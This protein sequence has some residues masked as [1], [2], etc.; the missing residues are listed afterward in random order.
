MADG[1]RLTGAAGASLPD[2]TQRA[3][4][5][6]QGLTA[7]RAAAHQ[8][9]PQAT[10]QAAKQFEA[11]FTQMM[12]KSMREAT[13]SGGLLGSDQEKMFNGMLDD[14]LAQQ[15]ASN[16]GIGLADLM[17]KQLARTGTTLPPA[18][19]GRQQ[20]LQGRA[21]N[22]A[23]AIGV[24][25]GAPA[26]AGEF[27]DRMATAA[28]NASASSGIPARFMLS[29]A[30]LESGWGKREI[31]RADGSTSYNVFGIKAGKNWNGPTV[32]VATTEYVNG[33]PRRVMAKF[34]AYHSYDEAFADYAN[35]I[36]KNPRYASVVASANDA[37][38]FAT[39]LQRAGYA[40]DPQYASKLIKIMKHFA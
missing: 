8:Q 16:K 11:V 4:Y 9:T 17:L 19:M 40:T 6:M 5:D 34:R 15:L 21:Y 32:E 27:V 26:V 23:D 35:L 22:S 14:Q 1:N 31:R 37:A 20:S 36:S 2:L 38:G 10:Q 39:N 24:A 13:M 3:S 18:A 29:Q 7:L 33:Q 12:V 28:Q 25:D 30:A